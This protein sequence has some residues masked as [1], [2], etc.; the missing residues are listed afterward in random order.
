MMKLVVGSV[1]LVMSG[2]TVT[3]VGGAM[4][5]L[6][7][8]YNPGD[9][10]VRITAAWTPD[11]EAPSRRALTLA[12]SAAVSFPPGAG[13]AAVVSPVDG[14]TLTQVGFDHKLG[15]HCTNGAPRWDV[16]TSDGSS[17]AFGC[18]AGI[19]EVELPAGGWERI[20]FS[21]EDV[22]VLNGLRGS[23]PLGTSQT[24]K[25]LQIVQDE[26]ASTT[27]DNLTVNWTVV[28]ALSR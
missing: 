2:I 26:A 8:I 14:V 3:P 25:T 27:L 24:L 22:Q 21:C 20:T 4:T 15:T 9:A 7:S 12:M 13:A 28:R 5:A 10:P 18:A 11:D 19:H 17:Y 1:L 6:A 23:C 16:E